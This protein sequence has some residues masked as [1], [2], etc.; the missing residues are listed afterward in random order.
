MG[1][2]RSYFTIKRSLTA[3]PVVADIIITIIPC[4]VDYSFT[5]K[6]VTVPFCFRCLY[7]SNSVFQECCAGLYGVCLCEHLKCAV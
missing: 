6:V 4:L 7:P 1:I 5:L 3:L 2:K